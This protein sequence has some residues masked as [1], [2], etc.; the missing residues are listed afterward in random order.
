MKNILI[1]IIAL[2][3]TVTYSQTS[4]DSLILS[5][6]N[7]YRIK[8]GLKNVYFDS[9]VHKAASFHSK[10][11]SATGDFQHI[12]TKTITETDTFNMK[13]PISRY[14]AAEGD[15]DLDKEN[16][17]EC[18]F[19]WNGSIVFNSEESDQISKEVVEEFVAKNSSKISERSILFWSTSPPHK[20]IL[21]KNSNSLIGGVSSSIVFEDPKPAQFLKGT[22]VVN[23]KVY[24]TYNVKYTR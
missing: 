7:T 3:S 11:M 2:I 14:V 8:G 16:Y 12:Q 20:D 24:I 10:Y 5:E 9:T 18:L 4:L 19:L 21:E 23:V 22:Y 1:I 17:R 13:N 6:I 15:L